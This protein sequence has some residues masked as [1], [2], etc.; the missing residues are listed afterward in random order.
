M[1]VGAYFLYSI[2]NSW[3]SSL[4]F[5]NRILAT[6]AQGNVFIQSN[7]IST[8]HKNI[9][10]LADSESMLVL[11]TSPSSITKLVPVRF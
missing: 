9:Q 2:Y 6:S 7:Y 5:I 1:A 4:P 11:F 3:V 8:V 10:T